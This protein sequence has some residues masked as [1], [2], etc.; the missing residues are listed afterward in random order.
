LASAGLRHEPRVTRPRLCARTF[1]EQHYPWPVVAEQ[2]EQVYPT[3]L[4]RS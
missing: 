3:V 1:I 2:I 4:E